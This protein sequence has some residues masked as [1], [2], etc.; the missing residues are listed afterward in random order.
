MS[1]NVAIRVTGLS[2]SYLIYKKPEDRLKQMFFRRKRYYREF[3]ALRGVDLEIYRGET[4]GILG[5]NGSGKTTMLELITGTLTATAGEVESHGKLAALLGLGAGFNP[6]FTGRENVILNATLLG[7]SRREV[8]AV[9]DRIVAF[10]E[11]DEFID[12]PVKTYS[13]G[14]YARLAF[15]V[16][17][18][19]EPD[20]LIVDETLSVGD[21][22]FQR[23]CFARIN[24][25]KARGSTILFVTHSATAVLELCDRAVLL[26]HGERLLTGEP[27][28][29]VAQYQRLAHAAPDQTE[30]IRAEIRAIDAGTAPNVV[31]PVT[32]APS[33]PAA[34]AE[35]APDNEAFFDS[36]LVSKSVQEFTPNGALIEDPHVEAL[37]GRRVNCLVHRRDYDFVYRVRFTGSH[38]QVR[39][40]MQIR[41]IKGVEL[42]GQNTHL[43]G[44]GITVAD[45]EEMTVRFPF[46]ASLIPGTYFLNAGVVCQ[47]DVQ[48]LVYLH[49]LVDVGVFRIAPRPRMKAG[50]LVDLR[51]G[52][53]AR[54][55]PAAATVSG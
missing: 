11:I 39:F 26:D 5:R 12:Q 52:R 32:A 21:E 4:V 36:G 13:S 49:R 9:F 28:V 41:T 20:I 27:R 44:E 10:A 29:V 45:G 50:G 40:G 31:R 42:T 7:L 18:H 24:D 3:W 48:G 43:E 38:R 6:E 33:R 14:M 17:I 16:A 19:V 30:S 46:R 54:V 25:L 23:K 15:S 22:A 53:E 34:V 8:D 2:K 51:A 55:E 1:S 47:D 35:D 37:D